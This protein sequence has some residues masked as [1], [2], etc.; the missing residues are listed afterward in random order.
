MKNRLEK[1]IKLL[2]ASCDNTAVLSIPYIFMLFTDLATEHAPQIKLGA[3]DLAEKGVFWVT[4][5]TKVQIYKRPKM[6]D[7]V[8]AST[9]PEKPGRIRCNR[10]YT[11]ND[12]S[13]ILVAGKSEW[14]IIDK[15]GHLHKT[16]EVYPEGLVHCEDVVCSDPFSRIS[17]DFSDCTVLG[18]YKIRSTDIDLA[19]H[20]NNA[21]Y[22]RVLF[23]A[24]TCKELEEMNIQE[25][26]IA[27][28]AQSYEGDTLTIKERKTENS[29]EFAMIRSDGI[30]A[31]TIIIK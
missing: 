19:Q 31:A 18:T 4:T 16:S 24:F 15:E 30:I 22:I 21:A 12:D 6:Q 17:D 28:K 27:F 29:R 20:M 26:E 23:G 3:D 13:G 5:K 11:L 7:T 2:T 14:A 10:Y 1:D 9:W 8:T 25:V